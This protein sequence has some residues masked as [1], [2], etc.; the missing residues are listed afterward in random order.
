M[1]LD[2]TSYLLGKKAGGGGAGITYQ[3]VEELPTVGE[4]GVIYLVPKSTSLEDNI[5]NEY[6]YLS[7]EWELIGDTQADISGK[8]DTMQYSTMPTPNEST[9]GKVVQYIGTTN[10]NYTNGY[11]YLGVTDGEDPATY[12]WEN[13]NVQAGEEP[14]Y[15]T[16]GNGNK[17]FT[18]MWNTDNTYK[19]NVLY[20][21]FK[22][23][24]EDR[25]N[26]KYDILIL[27]DFTG[28]RNPVE[29]QYDYQ[30]NTNFF[31]V[32]EFSNSSSGYGNMKLTSAIPRIQKAG[33]VQGKKIL[34]SGLSTIMINFNSQNNVMSATFTQ[35]AKTDIL[36]VLETNT[37][38]QTPY[39][40]L[41]P[42]SPA[43]KKYVDDSIASAITTALQGSY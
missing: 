19:Q 34:Q 5:Y 3:V 37:D 42:G 15:I 16:D 21:I 26:S 36:S 24:F 9:I 8:Q 38:Y 18:A 27:Y 2:T 12:S 6:M 14:R 28:A 7:G 11:F 29:N 31:V 35:V 40:P 1:A 20:P 13:L 17:I 30:K 41:Y 43:T 32:S 4:E 33:E 39:T 22:Q 25:V 10:N 23:I